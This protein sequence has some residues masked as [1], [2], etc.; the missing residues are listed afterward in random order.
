MPRDPA[1][2]PA[3]GRESTGDYGLPG[4]SVAAALDS[5]RRRVRPV[6]SAQPACLGKIVAIGSHL[7]SKPLHL[8]VSRPP[9]TTGGGSHYSPCSPAD[10][11]SLSPPPFDYIATSRRLVERPLRRQGAEEQA[12]CEALL[13]RLAAAPT[14]RHPGLG[15]GA[16]LDKPRRDFNKLLTD[17]AARLASVTVLDPACGSGNFLYVALRLLLDLEK[18]VITFAANHGLHLES[19]V[20][21]A[22]LHGIEINPYAQELASVVIWIGYLQWMRDNGFTAPNNPVLEPIESIERH[23]G[24][25][26]L[27][28]VQKQRFWAT[29]LPARTAIWERPVVHRMMLEMCPV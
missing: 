15:A 10:P 29:I 20:R 16:K 5:R 4:W 28:A 18:E 14:R 12:R 3:T 24:K 8:V 23:L 13:P 22:Q 7:S 19:K 21:P 9:T 26:L 25:R 17:F 27:D 1:G 11:S 2:Q 6:S